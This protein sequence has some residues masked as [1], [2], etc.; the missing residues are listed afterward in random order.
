[1]GEQARVMEEPALVMEEPALVME[2]P[3]LVME[4]PAP[5]PEPRR[6]HSDWQ[7]FGGERRAVGGVFRNDGER[8]NQTPTVGG[9]WNTPVPQASGR[10]MGIGHGQGA[11]AWVVH[12]P[13][14]NQPKAKLGKFNPPAAFPT[15]IR[16]SEKYEKW[17]KW[18]TTFDISLSICEGEPSE[19]QKVG[20]LFTTVGDEVREI[21]EMLELPPLHRGEPGPHGEYKELSE[22]LN[23]YFRSLVDETTDFARYSERKQREG[24]NVSRYLV[25]LRGLANRVGVAQESIGFRHQFLA[26]L[27]D[28]SLA[29]KA[30]VDGLDIGIVLRQAGRIEQASEAKKKPQ[31]VDEAQ[32]RGHGGHGPRARRKRS[33]NR[34]E[35][36]SF[37]GRERRPS[38]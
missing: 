10:P 20:L 16:Q 38:G 12:R 21:I 3:A 25:D 33:E 8:L 6:L 35:E 23:A 14:Q 34:I 19:K 18:K 26:G 24:E 22:G 32:P 31:W 29:E 37:H 27:A 13:T 7:H 17:L 4:E 5:V 28:R 36:A 15:D 9:H 11:P 2:E 30:A 1:M